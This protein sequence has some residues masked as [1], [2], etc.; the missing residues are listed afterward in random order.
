[1]EKVKPVLDTTYKPYVSAY[2]GQDDNKQPQYFQTTDC[3]Q[4]LK[5]V[6]EFYNK[7]TESVPASKK[8]KYHVIPDATHKTFNILMEETPDYKKA[9][10][11]FFNSKK[12]PKNLKK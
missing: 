8:P 1:M 10:A 11:D 3:K 7:P 12:N 9:T 4:V 2:K 6:A 5:K